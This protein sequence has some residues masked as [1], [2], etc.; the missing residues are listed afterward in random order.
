MILAIQNHN[1]YYK[2]ELLVLGLILLMEINIQFLLDTKL[3]KQILIVL[4]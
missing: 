1:S 2:G 4:L 3:E